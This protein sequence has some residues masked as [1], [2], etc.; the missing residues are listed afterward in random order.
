VKFVGPGFS[1]MSLESN[2]KARRNGLRM[3][4]VRERGNRRQ[5]D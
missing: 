4:R 2:R 5:T 1:L 3:I